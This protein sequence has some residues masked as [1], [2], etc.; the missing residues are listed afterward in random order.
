VQAPKPSIL[1]LFAHRSAIED[2]Q[3]DALAIGDSL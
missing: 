3:F 2:N 1:I